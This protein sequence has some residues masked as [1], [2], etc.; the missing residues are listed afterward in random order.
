MPEVLRVTTILLFINSM[1]DCSAYFILKY[2]MNSSIILNAY[3]VPYLI[4]WS[5]PGYIGLKNR[6]YRMAILVIVIIASILSIAILCYVPN[7]EEL[8]GNALIVSGLG[9][10]I[11]NLIYI[12]FATVKSNLLN[13]KDHPILPISCSILFYQTFNTLIFGLMNQIDTMALSFLWGF[14][15]ISYILLHLIIGIVFFYYGRERA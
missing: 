9:I 15:N 2:G 8:S 14:R 1:V 10:V 4:I 5:I 12:Y 3:I 13:F 6:S 7:Y 11:C